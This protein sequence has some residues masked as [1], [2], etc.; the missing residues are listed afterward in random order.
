ML[1]MNE[2]RNIFQLNFKMHRMNE[3]LK[4]MV[5]VLEFLASNKEIWSAGFVQHHKHNAVLIMLTSQVIHLLKWL[6]KN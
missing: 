1:W 6:K 2:V 3:D 4:N 5:M